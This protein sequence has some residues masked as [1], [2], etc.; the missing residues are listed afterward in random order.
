MKIL[1]RP[2]LRAPILTSGLDKHSTNLFRRFVRID[3]SRNNF[4]VFSG[5]SCLAID[6]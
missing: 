2:I 4:S 3:L 1:M 6:L 5:R